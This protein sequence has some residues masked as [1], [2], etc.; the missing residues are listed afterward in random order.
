MTKNKDGKNVDGK[1]DEAVRGTAGAAGVDA[2]ETLHTTAVKVASQT[3]VKNLKERHEALAAEASSVITRSR[4]E[5]KVTESDEIGTVAGVAGVEADGSDAGQTAAPT[6]SA[7]T[8]P[9]SKK[10]KKDPCGKCGEDVTLAGKSLSC[11]VCEFWFHYE[12]VPG[13]TKEYFDNCKMTRDFLGHSAFL[14][15]VC[16][17]V[18]A[19]F[20]RKMKDLEGEIE[21]LNER[22]NVLELEKE[23]LAQKVEN[24]EMK[25]D[26]VKEGLEGVEKEVVSGMEKAKEEVKQDMGREMK[27]REERSQNIV[28]YGLEEPSTS[29]VED[30][31]KEDKKRVEEVVK[32]I[33]VEM[34]GEIE[35]KFRAGKKMEGDAGSRPRPL[36]VQVSDD[37]TRERIFKGARN[38]SRVPRMK[39]VFIGQDL[40]WAQRE[41]ARK[42]EKQLRELADKKNEEAKNEGK[43]G[44]YVLVGQRGRRRLVWTD[45]VQ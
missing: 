13:M 17:K 11:Q 37:E 18:V 26:K 28:L 31:K 3:P 15:Q 4:R 35:I 42:E 12:C 24:M 44:K 27:E 20:N 7:P 19:K 29:T 43:S 38:L 14:C 16:R 41:E 9:P 21:K 25:T 22:V 5:R 45:R 8:A 30:K 39:N 6:A 10:K 23:T 2:R 32:E 34:K 1:E 33:G 36:I 40:T